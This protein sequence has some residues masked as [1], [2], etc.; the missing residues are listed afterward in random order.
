MTALS[1]LSDFIG[2]GVTESD[3]KTAFAG[4]HGFLIGLLGSDGT[5]LTARGQMGLLGRGV[6]IKTAAYTVTTDDCGQIIEASGTWAL[7]LPPV[8]G[9]DPGFVLSVVNTAAG[10]I[11]IDPD[12][13][14]LIDNAATLDLHPGQATLITCTGMGWIS[15]SPRTQTGPADA[16]PGRLLATHDTRG[17][18]GL[19][20]TDAP[21]TLADIDATNTPSGFWRTL[22]GAGVFPPN[23]TKNGILRLERHD[24]ANQAQWYL[25]VGTD[26]AWTR[27]YSAGTWTAWRLVTDHS[28]LL[29]TVSQS[30]GIPTGAV[31]ESGST[32][33]GEY[34]RFA[35]GTQICTAE[36]ALEALVVT[37]PT[38][39]LFRSVP[40]SHTFPAA[41]AGEPHF[42]AASFLGS[43][44][45]AIRNSVIAVMA[46]RG[47]SATWPNWGEI[48]FWSAA[49]AIAT[50]GQMTT[51]KLFAIGRWFN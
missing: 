15:L 43:D 9:L 26:Q 50:S 27:R 11:T 5:P 45:Q 39:A 30:G 10:V 35:N 17:A 21:P 7:A 22:G 13:A 42:S 49:A 23:V 41:F 28:S 46:E 16:S 33:T 20:S 1:P 38:G 8:A 36:V 32:P 51:V 6:L 44:N 14:E 31:F 29:G 25:P 19:G 37:T 48:I 34:V 2:A 24:A 4:A 3:F 12:G 18:F 40:V 47:G